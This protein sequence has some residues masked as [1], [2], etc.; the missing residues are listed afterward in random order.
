VRILIFSR[1]PSDLQPVRPQAA[2]TTDKSAPTLSMLPCLCTRMGL[3]NAQPALGP[4]P[5]AYPPFG[6]AVR[7]SSVTPIGAHIRVIC[8]HQR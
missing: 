5:R 3:H 8:V 7:W 1:G 6:A 4:M 2:P